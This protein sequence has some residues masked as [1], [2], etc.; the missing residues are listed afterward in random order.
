MIKLYVA[1]TNP[2]LWTQLKLEN[3]AEELKQSLKM[4]TLPVHLIDIFTE[5][6][7][8]TSC[9][10]VFTPE[11]RIGNVNEEYI[12][13]SD[14]FTSSMQDLS[15]GESIDLKAVDTDK[16]ID[17]FD[18]NIS[19]LPGDSSDSR[20]DEIFN[21][22]QLSDRTVICADNSGSDFLCI[23][24]ID[25][26]EIVSIASHISNERYCSVARICAVGEWKVVGK[27]IKGVVNWKI[28]LVKGTVDPAALSGIPVYE[29]DD[30]PSYITP[31]IVRGTEAIG[32]CFK[33]EKALLKLSNISLLGYPVD[34]MENLRE[35][36]K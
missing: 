13:S 7:V 4:D 5:Q 2:V 9:I 34:I 8:G 22:W 35:I 18:G 27:F 1:G 25:R 20:F 10:K 23:L 33:E 21:E 28:D 6:E 26:C 29:I 14:V 19:N 15:T 31:D 24:N 30:I 11:K 16:I 17:S 12:Y 32:V 36:H 3:A